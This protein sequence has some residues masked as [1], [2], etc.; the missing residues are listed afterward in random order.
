MISA[1]TGEGIDA[2]MER[3]VS[4]I[5]API[6]HKKKNLEALIIDSWFDQYVGVVSL[7]RIVNGKISVGDK[8][9]IMSTQK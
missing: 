6:D 4:D 1:K 8:I 2:L 5:P 7:L 3:I 9:K